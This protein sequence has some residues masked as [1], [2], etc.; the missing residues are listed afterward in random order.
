MA[1]TSG[2]RALIRAGVQRVIDLNIKVA[3]TVMLTGLCYQAQS[4]EALAIVS[5]GERRLFVE[6]FAPLSKISANRRCGQASA[7]VLI[8]AQ[9]HA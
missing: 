7:Q 2:E 1:E 3:L 5:L 9:S 6:A 4:S 8:K